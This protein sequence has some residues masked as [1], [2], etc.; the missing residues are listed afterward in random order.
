MTSL[1][2]PS[3]QEGSA[4]PSRIE[5]CA[6]IGDTHTLAL[7]GIDGSIDWLCLPRFDSGACFAALLGDDRNGRWLITPKGPIRSVRRRYLPQTLVLVTEFVTPEGV[8]R[9]TDCMTPRTHNPDVIRLI[10]GV[11]GSVPMRVELCIRFD[12]GHIV[13][14]V[15]KRD[16]WLCAVGG[17]DALWLDG[18]VEVT[19][20]NLQS[21]A[22]FT[23]GEGERRAMRLTW[24]ASN[25][26]PPQRMTDLRRGV[27]ETERWWREWTGHSTYDGEWG[28]AVERSLITLK[29]LTYSPTGAIVAAGTT[30]LPEAL[31]GMRN[32]D[33]RYSWLRDAT[34]TLMSLLHAGFAQE[35][36]AWREWLLRAI[37]GDP[38]DMK[39][40][41]GLCGERRLTETTLGWLPGYEGATPV[42]IGNAAHEQFQLDVYGEVMDAL[43]QSR[44]HGLEPD[45]RSWAVQRSLM[46]FLE[47][48]WMDADDG[49]WE[50]RGPRRNY[51]HSKVI[52]WVAADRAVK[53]VQEFEL[54]GPDRRWRRLRKEIFD[55]VCA[56]GYNADQGSFTQYYG[57]SELDAA[58]LLI[59]LVGFLP[60]TDKR[61]RGTVAAIEANLSR[62]G[63]VYRYRPDEGNDSVDGLPGTEGAFLACNFWLADNLALQGRHD[64]ARRV[65]EQL[66]AI[67]NDVGLLAEEYD[68]VAR[69]QVGNFPQAFS[70]VPLIN[71]AQC[72]S[73]PDRA[74]S[75][76]HPPKRR[77]ARATGRT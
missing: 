69:R 28:E 33:Y 22:D 68:P 10:E 51:T 75:H 63:F 20:E 19:G 56:K 70:H 60:P 54:D 41:Y 52:A 25:E 11:Q 50:M 37:A 61:V 40:M 14:W 47:S 65:F 30:S 62:D 17:P 42:R 53:A 26:G 49:I 58:L 4:V 31:G 74:T 15:R 29:A 9:V 3:T 36:Q 8:V 72:L 27:R 23:I 39:I 76:R 21:V 5:D 57:S 77:A 44:S 1:T 43:H 7:V 32:W 38:A 16:G 34:F 46:D 18:D 45:D 6:I 55:E 35:A 64:E 73:H 13:P 59:P 67:R 2:A 66:L 48:S 71:T 24:K 12:Y